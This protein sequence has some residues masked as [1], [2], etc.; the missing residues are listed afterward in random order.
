V[1]PP[2]QKNHYLLVRLV[3]AFWVA[4][5]RK[6]VILLLEDEVLEMVDKLPPKISP[7]DPIFTR[8]PARYANWVSG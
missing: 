3:G 1:L 6:K 5:L 7:K 8:I 4:N 2:H